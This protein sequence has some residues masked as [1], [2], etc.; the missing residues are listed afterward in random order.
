MVDVVLVNPNNRIVSPFA[1]VEP[2]LWLGLLA[3]HFRDKGN[4]VSILDAEAMDWSAS[5]AAQRIRELD[6][7][8]I[9]IV[10]MG[11]NPSVSSTPKMVA[12]KKIIDFLIGEYKIVVTGLHPSAL[13]RQTR[14]ELGVEVLRGK[15]FD[16]MPPVAYDLMPMWRYKAHNWHCLDGSPREPYASVYTSLGCPF[17]CSYCNIHA[18]YNWQHKV[19]FRDSEAV[20]T[21]LDLLARQYGVRNI[22]IWDELFALKQ[23]H[24]EAICDL[25][26]QREYKLNIWAYARVDTV[27]QKMLEK[28]KKAGINWLA[29]GFESGNDDVLDGVGKKSHRKDAI[30][31]VKWTHDAGINIG[32]NFI[33]GL[34]S[35]TEE[36]MRETMDFAKSLNIEWLNLYVCE[37]LPG[38]PIYERS[39]GGNNWGEFG[40]FSQ[41]PKRNGVLE[42]RDKAFNDFFT[43]ENYLNNLRNKFGGQAAQQIKDMLK[44]GKPVTRY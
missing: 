30:R 18:L 29:Y 40:Q 17:S 35:D 25:L 33:L 23:S 3:S 38:S 28:M 42:F 14:D 21:D 7:K 26:I 19:W 44:F 37:I 22:K 2:P 5:E 1:A 16:G 10:V 11:N 6:P 15:V 43:D 9:L 27:S 36:S 12:T 32:G 13:P 41:N 34:P 8:W 20:V 39:C 31:A 24:V 4:V